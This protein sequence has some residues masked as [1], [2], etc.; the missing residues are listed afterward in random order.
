[1]DG[2]D[3]GGEAVG[4]DLELD[5]VVDGKSASSRGDKE[6]ALACGWVVF[7]VFASAIDELCAEVGFFYF[8][9]AEIEAVW[10]PGAEA[11]EVDR[12]IFWLSNSQCKD[13]RFTRSCWVILPCHI[14]A[15]RKSAA[16]Q[17]IL[18]SH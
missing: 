1:M 5:G 8:G 6:D 16:G 12:L 13:Y 15:G 4:T 11:E 18:V 9:G 10:G 3:L 17:A 14:V 7:A 2:V